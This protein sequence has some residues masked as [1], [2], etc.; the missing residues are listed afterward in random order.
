MRLESP[1]QVAI[2]HC[3]KVKVIVYVKHLGSAFACEFCHNNGTRGD[4]LTRR[5]ELLSTCLVDS[6]D[7][8]WFDDLIVISVGPSAA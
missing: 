4:A 8:G 3:A 1:Q 7:Q 2:G 6:M 5:T